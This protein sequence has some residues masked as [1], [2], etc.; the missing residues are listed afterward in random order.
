MSIVFVPSRH[1]GAVDP[2]A[3]MH[4]WSLGAMPPR[5]KARWTFGG[6]GDDT[7]GDWTGDPTVDTGTPVTLDSSGL[8]PLYGELAVT[9]PTFYGTPIQ[10]SSGGCG[11]GLVQSGSN[12][13]DPTNPNNSL[14]LPNGQVLQGGSGQSANAWAAAIAS[15]IQTAGKVATVAV[16]PAGSYVSPTGA[17]TIGSTAAQIAASLSS[18]MPYILIGGGLVLVLAMAGKGNR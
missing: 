14:V 18:Y 1:L 13:F 11:A 15:A 6:L 2:A 4:P 9:T 10:A 16:A 3:R 7:G 8:N 5:P 17:V 12:C